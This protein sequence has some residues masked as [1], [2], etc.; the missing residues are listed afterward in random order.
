MVAP[1]SIIRGISTWA[2]VEGD[3]ICHHGKA[4]NGLGKSQSFLLM[5]IMVATQEGEG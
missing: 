2:T 4:Q 1:S 3:I 5:M